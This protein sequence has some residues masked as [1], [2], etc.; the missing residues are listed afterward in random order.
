MV[1]PKLPVS[2]GND[3]RYRFLAAAV[4]FLYLVLAVGTSFTKRPWVDEAYQA[5]CSLDVITR[6]TAGLSVVEPSGFLNRPG[7]YFSGINHYNYLWMPLPYYLFAAWFKLF[8]FSLFSMRLI[9]VT[10]GLLVLAA[11]WTIVWRLTG[12]R[13]L[14]LLAM[15]L[16]GADRIVVDAASDGRPDM[17]AGAFCYAG[18]AAYLYLRT[19]NF[20]LAIFAGQFLIAMGV[21]SHPVAMNGFFGMVFLVFY[22]DRSRLRWKHLFLAG[23]PHVLALAGWGLFILQDRADFWPQ[24]A[25]SL[26]S[27][28]TGLSAPWQAVW[29]EISARY[30]A[31]SYLPDYAQGAS[32]LRV[33]IPIVYFLSAIVPWFV[34]ELRRSPGRRA[35]LILAA[36]YFCVMTFAEGIKSSYYLIHIVPILAC[37][38]A[39]CMQWCWQRAALCRWPAVAVLAVFLLVQ[40]GWSMALIR[41]NDYRNTYLPVIAFLQEHAHKSDII[42]GTSEL[43]YELGF[44][45]NLIEDGAFGYYTKKRADFIVIDNDRSLGQSIRAYKTYAPWLYT[46]ETNLLS[47]EY[48]LVY[49]HRPY[50]IYSRVSR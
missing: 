40:I 11:C 32:R 7:Q 48:Q 6:G 13:M 22:L 1:D 37:T 12:D 17:L 23:L 25:A 20:D 39:V 42:L 47:H 49:D 10:C 26:R 30:L 5:N 38:L 24:F 46:Y 43:G 8:G 9:S 34:P 4:V 31:G 33:I 50:T 45:D 28:G 35:L 41:R 36:L 2:G 21:F 15:F 16:V 27:R 29:R 3:W 14:A 18:L 44:Y 19:K